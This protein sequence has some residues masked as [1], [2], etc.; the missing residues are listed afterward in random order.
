MGNATKWHLEYVETLQKLSDMPYYGRV[1]NDPVHCAWS[2]MVY[3]LLNG[4]QN[5]WM[6]GY[7]GQYRLNR[8][9]IHCF[10]ARSDVPVAQV[11]HY[12]AKQITPSAVMTLEQRGLAGEEQGD[13][14]ANRG[15]GGI[16]DPPSR[17]DNPELPSGPGIP[18]LRIAIVI[19]GDGDD[20]SQD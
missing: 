14:L 3:D 15:R 17:G 18:V 4:F 19:H 2:R 7:G 16:V 10:G 20:Y 12:D 1:L 8:S 11:S 13:D 9:Q 6:D 5:V